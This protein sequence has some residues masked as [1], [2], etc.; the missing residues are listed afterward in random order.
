MYFLH[1]NKNN[2]KN[3]NDYDFYNMSLKLAITN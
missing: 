1:D 3:N 2:N